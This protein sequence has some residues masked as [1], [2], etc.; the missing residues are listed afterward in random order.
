MV[1]WVSLIVYN[2]ITKPTLV[3]SLEPM[4]PLGKD[5]TINQYPLLSKPNVTRKSTKD[6]SHSSKRKKVGS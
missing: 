2:L 3:T 4:R 5:E 6:L 1:G